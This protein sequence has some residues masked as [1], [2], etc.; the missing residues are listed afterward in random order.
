MESTTWSSYLKLQ[1]AATAKNF[2]QRVAYGPAG[3]EDADSH[4]PFF[5]GS[6]EPKDQ[7]ALN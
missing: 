7:A 5:Y 2:Q 6:L 4:N 3:K 1:T